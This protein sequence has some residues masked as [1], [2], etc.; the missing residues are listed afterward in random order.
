MDFDAE[1]LNAYADAYSDAGFWD[2]LF[3]YAVKIG[4]TLVEEALVLYYSLQDP[5]MPAWA[6]ASIIGAL[7]YLISP[8][9]LIPDVIPVVGFTDDAGVIAA[10]LLLIKAYIKDEHRA[11]ARAKIAEFFGEEV[12]DIEAETDEDED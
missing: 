4:R 2:K 12:L 9:D 8:I 6:K 7:G 5:S 3:T 10:V 1:E 11:R